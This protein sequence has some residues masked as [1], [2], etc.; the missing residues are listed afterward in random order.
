MALPEQPIRITGGC[1]CGA[2][3]YDFTFPPHT[4]IPLKDNYACLCTLCRKFTGAV[5]PRLLSVYTS[6]SNIPL[7]HHA[8]EFRMYTT[9]V[10]DGFTGHRGFC[11]NCGSSMG[12]HHD[13]IDN[14][15]GFTIFLGTVDEEVLVGKVIGE[16]EGKY[17]ARVMRKGGFAELLADTSKTGSIWV[18]NA[19]PGY[20]LKGP[21]KW[22][23]EEDEGE[24]FDD[25]E[26]ASNAH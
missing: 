3:R 19:T 26:K 12:T 20:D 17:G 24:W 21:K 10:L 25:I 22:R 16:E 8:P 13:P 15:Q 9:H 23:G 14:I 5:V 4:E 7:Y 6:W 18:E 2:L 1:N 11:G